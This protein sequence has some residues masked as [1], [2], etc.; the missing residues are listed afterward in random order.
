MARA[1][2]ILSGGAILGAAEFDRFRAFLDSAPQCN[3]SAIY[4]AS[5]IM[6]FYKNVYSTEIGFAVRLV[7]FG[8]SPDSSVGYYTFSHER[9]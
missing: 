8:W 7:K 5:I 3:G 9:A 4:K 1:C 6:T 2:F